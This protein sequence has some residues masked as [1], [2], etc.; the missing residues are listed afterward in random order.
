MA[1][2]KPAVC[3]IIPAYNEGRRVASVVRL[4]LGSGLFDEVVVVD[5]GS[6]DYTADAAQAAGARVVVHEVNQGKAAAMRTGLSETASEYVCFLDADLIQVTPE[7]LKSLIDAVCI[8]GSPAS[9]AAFSG[10]RT[11]T[12]L[13][14]RIAPLISGQRCFKRDLLADFREWNC[15]FGIETALNAYLQG[16]RVQQKIVYWHGAG[17]V[18]KEEKHG[19]LAGAVARVRMYRDILRMWMKSRRENRRETTD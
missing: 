3:A 11:A 13:A 19:L 16:R 1:D 17:Q 6:R 18:M 15:G 10:G 8:D 2:A 9:I 14:Q 7:H 4:A 12:T 5:D